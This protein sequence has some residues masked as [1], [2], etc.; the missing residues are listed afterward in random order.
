MLISRG[1]SCSASLGGQAAVSRQCCWSIN[2]PVCS[3][4][5]CASG[6]RCGSSGRFADWPRSLGLV[7]LAM[8]LP[9][10]SITTMLKVFGVE[11]W[12]SITF[13][14]PSA[15]SG[16]LM[17]A[18]CLLAGVEVP[19]YGRDFRAPPSGDAGSAVVVG[20]VSARHAGAVG[21]IL[22]RGYRS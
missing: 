17:Y 13:C 20:V 1:R 21:V 18:G 16:S 5:V 8:V 7:P 12:Y 6:F 11:P 10:G 9:C 3:P 14:Q 19:A 2:P 22:L 15:P 4:R